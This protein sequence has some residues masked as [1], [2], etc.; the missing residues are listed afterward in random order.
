M[1]FISRT[2]VT[3]P[4]NMVGNSWW[5]SSG[6]PF[7]N[8]PY[9]LP[10][11]TAYAYGRYA[12]IRN[13]FANLP[14]VDAQDWYSQAQ[15]LGFTTNPTTPKLG[16][17]ACWSHP[18]SGGHIAIVE[19]INQDG[20]LNLSNS[21]YGGDYFVY[22]INARAPQYLGESFTTYTNTGVSQQYQGSYL[23]NN[24]TFLGFIYN[25]YETISVSDYVI[26][27][28]A[29]VWN[30]ESGLNPDIWE[31]LK[32]PSVDLGWQGSN[33]EYE[34][35]WIGDEGTG[36]YGL[37]AWTNVGEQQGFLYNMSEYARTHG[38]QVT[39]RTVEANGQ[40]DAFVNMPNWASGSN[41]LVY[42]YQTLSEFLSSSETNLHNLVTEFFVGWESGGGLDPSNPNWAVDKRQY[43]ADLAYDYIQQH[44]NDDVNEYS[45][46]GSNEYIANIPDSGNPQTDHLSAH[47]YNN[48]MCMYFWFKGYSPSPEPPT[49]TPTRKGMPLW[50]MLRYY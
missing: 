1:P 33:W 21:A 5:Y 30:L 12:E 24:Y 7:Y 37:G 8:T 32:I 6:N 48:L 50:M 13:G 40:L 26:A 18:T 22:T 49:P 2:S 19:S 35:A 34:F 25:D 44:K 28:I 17:I 11:C 23:S 43:S 36:G 29:G 9:F 20:S 15:S 42:G 39:D 47:T 10:N 46:Y 41:Y 31:S 45:W 14:T 16:A 38:Y 4:S 3:S 27:A